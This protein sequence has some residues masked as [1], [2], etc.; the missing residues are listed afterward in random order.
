MKKTGRN[1]GRNVG[2]NVGGL[3]QLVTRFGN[4]ITQVVQDIHGA[5]ANPFNLRGHDYT[6]LPWCT[7]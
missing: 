5:V 7:T 3:A 4:E 2:R 1:A 6:P